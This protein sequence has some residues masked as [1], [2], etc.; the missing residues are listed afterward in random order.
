MT[1]R[2]RLGPTAVVQV[3]PARLADAEAICRIYNRAVVAS[4]ATFDTEPR[5]VAEERRRLKDPDFPILV[6]E[7]RGRVVGWASLSPWSSR[8]AYARTAETSVY[9][10]AASRGRGIGRRLLAQLLQIARH[11]GFRTLLARVSEE[12][13]PSL[14]LHAS[15]GFRPV[16]VMHEVG[17]KFGRWL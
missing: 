17:F 13:V 11:R 9:V 7:R 16:G 14:H 2:T 4:T 8:K 1:A 12:S 3:R 6:A 15:L 10:D 5:T